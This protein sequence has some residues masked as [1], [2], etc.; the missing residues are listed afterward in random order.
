MAIAPAVGAEPKGQRLGVNVLFGALVVVVFGSMAGEWLSVKQMLPGELWYF[1]L[2]LVLGSIVVEL[3]YF[4]IRQSPQHWWLI[5]WAAFLGLFVL[6]AVPMR[7]LIFGQTQ[8]CRTAAAD[9]DI[10]LMV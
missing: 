8:D 7:H 9:L 1:L 10:P 3:L 5:T 2:G 6:L 4:I